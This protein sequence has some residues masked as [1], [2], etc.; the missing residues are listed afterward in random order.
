MQQLSEIMRS[1][2]IA[3]KWYDLGLELVDSYSA[4]KTIETDHPSN[5]NTCCRLM[6]EKWL[7]VKSDASW[8]HLITALNKIE[9]KAAANAISKLF[10]SGIVNICTYTYVCIS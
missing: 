5:V 4:V 8:S 1:E 9:M 10:I 2:H 6:F 3:I 7:E